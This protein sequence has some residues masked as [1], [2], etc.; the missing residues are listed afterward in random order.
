[1]IQPNYRAWTRT[2]CWRPALPLRV[3]DMLRSQWPAGSIWRFARHGGEKPSSTAEDVLILRAEFDPQPFILGPGAADV[4]T[5]LQTGTAFGVAVE[6][7]PDTFDL[8]ALLNLLL[9]QNAITQ[10]TH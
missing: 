5:A 8:A 7:A 3:D 1:L 10:L 9:S 2:L 6:A 4:V